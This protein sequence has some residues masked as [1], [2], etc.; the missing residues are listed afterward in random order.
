MFKELAYWMY[1]FWNKNK[2]VRKNEAAV[3]NAMWT[4]ALLWFLNLM[5]LHLL[6]ELW[7]WDMLTGWFSS[8]MGMVE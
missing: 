5:A 1:Y 6:F 2:R 4:M 7:G 3:S 8:L